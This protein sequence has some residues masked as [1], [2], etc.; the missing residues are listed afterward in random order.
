MIQSSIH[1]YRCWGYDTLRVCETIQLIC[2]GE[3]KICMMDLENEYSHII[4]TFA[5]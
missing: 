2:L 3:Y 4:Y 5:I 1:W